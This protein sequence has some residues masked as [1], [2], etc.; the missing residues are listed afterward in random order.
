MLANTSSSFKL[1][2]ARMAAATAP[3]VEVVHTLTAN[4]M[5]EP[6]PGRYVFDFGQGISGFVRL[7]VRGPRGSVIQLSHGDVLTYPFLGNPKK[8]SGGSPPA[9]PMGTIYIEDLDAANQTDVYTL[10]GTDEIET[11][12]PWATTHGFRYVELQYLT[13]GGTPPTLD[14]VEAFVFAQAWSRAVRLALM[15]LMPTESR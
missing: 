2:S 11:F 14:T 7:K 9:Q 5:Q 15:K 4:R 1:G 13:E 3:A 10:R 12:E 6:A 8:Y